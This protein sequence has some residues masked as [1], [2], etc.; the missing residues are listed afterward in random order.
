MWPLCPGP[1]PGA[2]AAHGA[3]VRHSALGSRARAQW[4]DV[5]RLRVVLPSALLASLGAERSVSVEALLLHG[6]MPT[7]VRIRSF[8]LF[9]SRLRLVLCL[10]LRRVGTSSS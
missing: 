3:P 9:S 5:V 10:L 1:L 6:E 8:V 7:K 2:S 4:S